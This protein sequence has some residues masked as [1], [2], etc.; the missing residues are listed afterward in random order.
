MKEKN[1][2]DWGYSS[3]YG[4]YSVRE[5]IARYLAIERGIHVQPSQI[6]LTLGARQTMDIIAQALLKEGDL[7]S[8]EDPGFPVAWSSMK[9]R[10]MQVE[11]IPVDSQGICVEKVSPKSKMIFTTPSHQF[12]SGVLMTANRRQELIQF[13]RQN[14][15]WI[16]EDDYDGEFRY[17]G[18]PMPSLYSQMPTNIL[19]ILSFTKLL[20]P[21]IRLAA[22]IGPEEA[23][24]RMAKVQEFVCRHLPVMEQL[25]LG[26]FFETGDLL[27]HVRRMR[28]I[29]HKRHRA[30]IHV[31][32]EFGLASEFHVLGTESGLHVL[33]EGNEDF[34]ESKAVQSALK[35][36][37]GVFPLSPYCLESSRKG[38]LLGFAHLNEDYIVEGIRRL[39]NVL[40]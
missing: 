13:A 26:Q 27:K 34:D 28:S 38:L 40:L 8:V 30:I 23:I 22:V 32:T 3:P 18:G 14:Q 19:Y 10:H 7:V 16:I 4:L 20:A 9:Y 1:I 21:G 2:L 6:L 33:L 24:A 39:A 25:T 31:L 37:V 29:Y 35:V 15:T 17:R 12:P 36:G 11:P 5:Q